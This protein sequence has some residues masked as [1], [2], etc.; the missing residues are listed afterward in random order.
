MT[1]AKCLP[2][3]HIFHFHCLRTWLERSSTCPTCR[4]A[5]P[6]QVPPIRAAPA[7]AA[8]AGAAAPAIPPGAASVSPASPATPNGQQIQQPPAH[9]P[10]MYSHVQSAVIPQLT[11]IIAC[12]LSVLPPPP[13]PLPPGMPNFMPPMIPPPP[14][15]LVQ[16]AAQH[17]VSSPTHGLSMAIPPPPPFANFPN[18]ELSP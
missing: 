13:P 3:G 18:G 5:I 1:S 10:C 14:E 4:A 12:C 6:E 15:R 2:C 7:P 9:L 17:P 11:V 16:S 8:P